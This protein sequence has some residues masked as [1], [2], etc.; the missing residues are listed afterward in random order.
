MLNEL[1]ISGGDARADVGGDAGADSG[2]NGAEY[3]GVDAAVG[4]VVY[5]LSSYLVRQMT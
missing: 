5:S 4:A 2:G 1:I 3:V